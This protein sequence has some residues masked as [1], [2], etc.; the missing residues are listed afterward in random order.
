M[1]TTDA[2]SV[3]GVAP[4]ASQIEV[5]AA[6]RARLSLLHPDRMAGRSEREKEVAAAMLA[7]LQ[8]AWAAVGTDKARARY[9]S[10][11]KQAETSRGSQDGNGAWGPSVPV[12]EA[13]SAWEQAQADAEQRR[14]LITDE[15]RRCYEPPLPPRWG[16]QSAPLLT[17]LATGLVALS[18]WSAWDGHW[19]TAGLIV[20]ALVVGSRRGRRLAA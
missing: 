12:D 17:T 4:D 1:R 6:Y 18:G 14:A 15:L 19:A 2:Y 3:L 16:R 13:H 20:V 9:D 7:E 8:D 10:E 11:R 5:E